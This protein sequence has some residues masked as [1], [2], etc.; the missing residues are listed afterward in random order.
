MSERKTQGGWESQIKF[1][2]FQTILFPPYSAN[3]LACLSRVMFHYSN[4]AGSPNFPFCVFSSP[5]PYFVAS[6]TSSC[7]Q[8]SYPAKCNSASTS[9]EQYSSPF[10]FQRAFAPCFLLSPFCCFS[11]LFEFTFCTSSEAPHSCNDFI[12]HH[13]C[14]KYYFINYVYVSEEK[15]Q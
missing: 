7:Q 2:R 10:S 9:S 4:W 5:L 15:K 8:N 14:V 3:S 6:T 1:M 13:L 12:E 11:F